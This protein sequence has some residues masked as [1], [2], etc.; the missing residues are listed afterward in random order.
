MLRI[1]TDLLMNQQVVNNQGTSYPKEGSTQ[2]GMPNQPVNENIP[3]QHIPERR[4]E[5]QNLIGEFQRPPEVTEQEPSTSNNHGQMKENHNQ[6]PILNQPWD[7]PLDL[8]PP[9][10]P[11]SI[12]TSQT[13]SSVANT[14]NLNITTGEYVE[15][16][17][18]R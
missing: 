12:P 6:D 14:L 18:T 4:Q 9:M 1:L 17:T 10:R 16:L 13:T 3:Y 8:Q 15:A 7:E 2:M 5:V 11:M